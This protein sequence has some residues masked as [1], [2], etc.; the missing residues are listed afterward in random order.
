MLP[1][2]VKMLQELREQQNRK[3]KPILDEHLIADINQEL[4]MA[5][6]HDLTIELEYFKNH[7]YHRISGKLLGVNPLLNYL[8]VEDLEI[9]LDD[10]VVAWIE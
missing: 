5:L 4:Q 1:E 9:W 8:K 10:V 7:D 6:E 3:E 2:Q